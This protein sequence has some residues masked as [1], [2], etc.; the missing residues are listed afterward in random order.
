VPVLDVVLYPDDPLRAKAA[1]ITD[2]GPAVIKLAQ[3]MIETMRE[4]E[5]VGLAGPQVGVAK[6]IFIMCPPDGE[7][8][9]IVNPE[10]VEMEGRAEG[11]EGC[12][13]LPGIYAPNVPRATRV[14]MKA[15]DERGNPLE[16]ELFDFEARIAQHEFD[17]LEGTLFFDR[18][19]II[20]RESVLR[21]WE[22]ARRHM[23][24]D[25]P[26]LTP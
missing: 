9:C 4:H 14:R 11:E 22:E 13:S 6:R 3:D 21:D 12:L 5:G 10:F 2:F 23:F 25:A 15:F 17:H 8:R 24:P 20:T 7:P 16:L 26:L 1:P 18:V 19:D